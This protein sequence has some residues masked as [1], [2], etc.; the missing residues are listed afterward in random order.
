MSAVVQAAFGERRVQSLPA[1]PTGELLRTPLRQTTWC[2]WNASKR[3]FTLRG[4]F[5][6]QDLRNVTPVKLLR[7]ILAAR[8]TERLAC[9][10][11]GALATLGLA[12][13]EGAA[14]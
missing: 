12:E 1:G 14:S 6:L 3:A 11:A 2:Y 7:G 5:T 13:E 9:A 8:P 10:A 4:I